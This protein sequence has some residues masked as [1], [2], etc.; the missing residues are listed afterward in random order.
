MTLDAKNIEKALER[1]LNKYLE[2]RLQISSRLAIIK[3]K[4]D[5]QF[6]VRIYVH[7]LCL[8]HMSTPLLCLT[9]KPN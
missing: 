8:V 4:N 6:D 2:P 1:F 5:L 9:A 3:L 7:Y